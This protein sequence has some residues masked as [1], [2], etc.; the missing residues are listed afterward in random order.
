VADREGLQFFAHSRRADYVVD[1]THQDFT[2]SGQRYGLILDLTEA[3]VRQFWRYNATM[4]APDADPR[5]GRKL[6]DVNQN[7]GR[8]Q[9]VG[10]GDRWRV[11]E[12]S[13]DRLPG[14]PMGNWTSYLEA[15]AQRDR[16]LSDAIW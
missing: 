16:L 13:E 4:A 1:D 14:L 11:V 7:Q 5:T 9:I 15:A 3:L 12:L 2:R 6:K 8:F 10:S